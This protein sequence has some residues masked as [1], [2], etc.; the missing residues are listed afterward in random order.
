V[1]SRLDQHPHVRFFQP[2]SYFLDH[3]VGLHRVAPLRP[4]RGDP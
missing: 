2:Q 3:G 1:I 4:I